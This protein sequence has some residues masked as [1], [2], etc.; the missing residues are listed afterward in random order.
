MPDRKSLASR[1]EVA[2]YLGLVDVD[3]EPNVQTL[4]QWAHRGIGPKYIRVGR[5]ARYRW[6]DVEQWLREQK[7]GGGGQAA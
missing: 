3:G 4:A 6:D 2:S 7:T 1:A 5:H